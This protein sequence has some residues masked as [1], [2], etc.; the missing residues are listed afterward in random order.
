MLL[1]IQILGLNIVYLKER[2]VRYLIF[3]KE[4]TKYKKE[5][6]EFIDINNDLIPKFYKN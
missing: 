2:N 4:D 5:A 3:S 6:E 1:G